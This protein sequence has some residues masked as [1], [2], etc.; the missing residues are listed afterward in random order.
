MW[1]TIKKD[2]LIKTIIVVLIGVLAFGFAFNIMFGSGSSTMEEGSMMGSGYSLGNTL[3]SIIELLIKVV[4]IGLLIGTIVWIFRSITKQTVS[5]QI[6]HFAWLREDPIIRNALIIIGG[7]AVLLF[8]IWF[9][10]GFVTLRSGEEMISGGMAYS[11]TLIPLGITSIFSF[12]LKV[13]I[14]ILVLTLAY[15]VVMYMKE[16]YINNGFVKEPEL[17]KVSTKECPDCNSKVKD[18]W[19]CC[20]YC[21]SDKAFEEVKHEEHQI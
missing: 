3:E 8:G 5:S 9:L 21:G 16:N 18:N 19:K 6:D 17:S 12:I 1:E 2:P 15:G 7:V 4:I 11:T 10:R 13:M 14:F 20:P